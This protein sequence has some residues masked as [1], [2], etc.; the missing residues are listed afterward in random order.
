MRAPV[1]RERVAHEHREQDEVVG[2]LDAPPGSAG[3]VGGA[4]YGDG[5]GLSAER[6]GA[7]S[8]QDVD[9]LIALVVAAL[10]RHAVEAQQA[11]LEDVTPGVWPEQGV[12]ALQAIPQC[13][14]SL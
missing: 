14:A 7:A 10:V 3:D 2:P 6:H 4:A 8:G 5:G 1:R 12:G 11:L 13:S 9:H